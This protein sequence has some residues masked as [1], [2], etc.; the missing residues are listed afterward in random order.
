[1]TT[2]SLKYT[3]WERILPPTPS[4]LEGMR[5]AVASVP[6]TARGTASARLPAAVRCYGHTISEENCWVYSGPRL[7]SGYGTLAIDGLS[8]AHRISWVLVN[9]PIPTGN[10]SR[11]LCVCHTC[12]RPACVNPAHLFLGTQQENL[13]DMRT[14]GRSRFADNK[15][16]R[17]PHAKLTEPDVYEL[18]RLWDAGADGSSLGRKFGI[19]N[20]HAIDIGR[21][22][23]WSSLPEK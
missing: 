10:G 14:K 18:R 22:K 12:D 20:V 16:Q 21:R 17:N 3:S 9:G 6:L 23:S 2:P 13:S 19:T 7:K 11:L 15:G 8:L 5:A 1:M 4:E